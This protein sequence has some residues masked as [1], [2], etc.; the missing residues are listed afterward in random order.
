MSE[1]CIIHRCRLA[2]QKL[3]TLRWCE[4]IL[5]QVGDEEYQSAVAQLL[6]HHYAS[7]KETCEKARFQVNTS[8][9]CARLWKT[10][11][12][13]SVHPCHLS[14]NRS[15]HHAE[16]AAAAAEKNATTGEGKHN[17]SATNT[18]TKPRPP[19]MK[20]IEVPKQVGF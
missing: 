4:L 8:L 10:A 19:K 9:A 7:G 16:A 18:T 15:V 14:S 20:T 5:A 2:L 3:F 17:N 6:C 13:C 1:R 11:H 12:Q